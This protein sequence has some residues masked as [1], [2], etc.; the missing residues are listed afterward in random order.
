[1]P[2]LNIRLD[3]LSASTKVAQKA[4]LREALQHACPEERVPI[5]VRLLALNCSHGVAACIRLLDS[6]PEFFEHLVGTDQSALARGITRIVDAGHARSIEKALDLIEAIPEPILTIPLLPVL[7]TH[8]RELCDA[9]G[10]AILNTATNV[11]GRNGRREVAQSRMQQLENLITEALLS[12][13]RHRS[14]DVL[15]ATAL[16]HQRAGKTLSTVLNET[17]TPARLAVQ[18]VPR[19]LEHPVVLR[20]LLAWMDSELLGRQVARTLHQIAEPA[21]I[22]QLLESSHLLLSPRRRRMMRNV[23]RAVRCLV[24]LSIVTTLPADAQR[25]LPRFVAALPLT[26]VRRREYCADLIAA[27]S[28]IARWRTIELLSAHRTTVAEQ[29]VVRFARDRNPTVAGVAAARVLHSGQTTDAAQLN[30]L[31]HIANP[32]QA[33]RA[34]M[35]S[36]GRDAASFAA[37][38]STLKRPACLAATRRLLRTQPLALFGQFERMLADQ[39]RETCLTAIFLVRRLQLVEQFRQQLCECTIS[40]DSQV[41]SAAV[42]A[43]ADAPDDQVF[44]RVLA[45][46]RNQHMRVRANAIDALSQLNRRLQPEELKEQIIEIISPHLLS[47]HNRERANALRAWIQNAPQT[48]T[49]SREHSRAIIG[50][51]DMLH[52]SNPM[53][54][55]S[56]IWVAGR[57]RLPLFADDLHVAAKHDVAQPVRRRAVAALQRLTARHVEYAA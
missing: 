28:P 14:V 19:R 33:R 57:S 35:F 26:T 48:D 30:A 47:R 44:E 56:A 16:L 6:H 3:K 12:Y 1:M 37:M 15:L 8:D 25:M 2:A 31:Q 9:V 23:D 38:C 36:A 32:V 17:G 39:H 43:L 18:G 41:C 7:R 13:E 5:A 10:A 21:A 55:I 11:L 46:L 53:H 4:I 54:R 40:D 34:R 49:S 20:N 51:R 24:D 52:D 27:P 45:L 29:A 22:A 50:L 42:S